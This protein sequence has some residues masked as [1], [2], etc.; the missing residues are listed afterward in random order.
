MFECF[1]EFKQKIK[2]KVGLN[3]RDVLS[4][5]WPLVV[6][7][8]LDMLDTADKYPDMFTVTLDLLVSPTE[9]KQGDRRLPWD[10]FPSDKLTP[11]I[12]FSSK[13]EIHQTFSE[14]GKENIKKR[15]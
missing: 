8:E 13:D 5:L 14:F 3:I 12:L 9:K 6:R 1:K 10:N 7:Y 15:Y 4:N 11:K 2:G